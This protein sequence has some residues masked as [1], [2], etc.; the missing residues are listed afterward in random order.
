MITTDILFIFG[1]PRSGTTYVDTLLRKHFGYALCSEGGFVDTFA[2]RQNRYGDLPSTINLN[3][4]IKDISRD[5]ML[6]HFRTHFSKHYGKQLEVTPSD[7]WRN[8]PERSWPGIIYAVFASVAEQMELPRLGN[9]NPGYSYYLPT[10]YS[11]FPNAKFLHVIRDGRDVALSNREIS[12]GQ[13]SAYS[14]AKTWARIQRAANEFAT[15]VPQHQYYDFYYEKLLQAPEKIVIE[16]ENFLQ[17]PLNSA[18]RMN[19]IEEIRNNSKRW[20]FGKWK[21]NM[22]A[23]DIRVYEAVAGH[24]LW[25]RGYNCYHENPRVSDFARLMYESDEYLRKAKL[26][27]NKFFGTFLR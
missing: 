7:I 5:E 12:W 4:L 14:N 18:E 17:V 2:K 27:L 21:H 3:R 22:V 15:R 23:K 19:F 13:K 8:L 25:Q 26:T 10:L 24:W 9:K 16:L 6:E 11:W 1:A 20:N